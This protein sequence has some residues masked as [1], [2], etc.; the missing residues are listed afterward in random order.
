MPHE[1]VEVGGEAP[2]AEGELVDVTGEEG[3]E[4]AGLQLPKHLTSLG[5]CGLIVAADVAA[6]HLLQKIVVCNKDMIEIP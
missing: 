5:V 6:I 2:I 1:G 3:I 4:L